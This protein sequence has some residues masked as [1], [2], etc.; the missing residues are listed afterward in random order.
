G[1]VGNVVNIADLLQRH[2]AETVRFLLLSSHYRSPIEYSEERLDE[3]AKSLQA[4]YTLFDRYER[5]T[6]Q[7]FYALHEIGREEFATGGMAGIRTEGSDPSFPDGV[8]NEFMRAMDDDFNTG[9]AIGVL[10]KAVRKANSIADRVEERKLPVEIA[11]Y[12]SRM[13]EIRTM[14]NILGLFWAP[15]AKKELGGGDQLVA[16]LMQ[17]LLDLRNN[18]RATAKEAAKDN[19]LKKSLFDQ[20]DLIRKRLAE[21]GVTLED[22]PGGT[23]WRVG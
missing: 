16:G 18:L 1:S 8:G 19:P 17:L 21:L 2:S 23:T 13:R 7:S 15:P 11:L 10:F 14:A 20:T 3:I 6:G 5:L 22:R 4:F 9:E 12:D